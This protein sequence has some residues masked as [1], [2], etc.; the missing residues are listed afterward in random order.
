MRQREE[1][2]ITTA[3]AAAKRGAHS[4]EVEPPAENSA[5]SKPWIESSSRAWTIRSPP[6]SAAP[7][8]TRPVER[9]EAKGTSSR[10][11]KSRSRNSCS[12]S[13]PTCPVAPT[14]ATRDPMLS[15]RSGYRGDDLEQLRESGEVVGVARVERELASTAD[16]QR[17][18]QDRDEH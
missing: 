16:V 8:S 6:S 4:P 14:T 11:G 17:H 3:P 13:V 10:A 9:S 2:S 7:S 18:E 1:L 5:M 15:M 12:I